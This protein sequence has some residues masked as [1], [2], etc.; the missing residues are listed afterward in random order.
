M[1]KTPFINSPLPILVSTRVRLNE[2]QRK[3]L[4]NA[5]FEKKNAAIPQERTTEDGLVVSTPYTSP[6]LDKELGMNQLVFSDLV[7]SRDTI[8]IGIVLKLQQALGVEVI[9]KKEVMAACKSYCDYI[10]N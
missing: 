5:Y 6:G 9:T 4:K 7:N 3:A 10:F 1:T 8:T 2:E